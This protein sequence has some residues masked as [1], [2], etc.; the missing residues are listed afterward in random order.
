MQRQLKQQNLQVTLANHGQ[1]AIDILLAEG[2]GTESGIPIG[3]ILMDIEVSA[4]YIVV[5]LKIIADARVL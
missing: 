1:E 4:R 5:A 3:I 2:N